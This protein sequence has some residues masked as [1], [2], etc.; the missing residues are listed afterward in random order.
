[1]IRQ[2]FLVAI[3]SKSLQV[4]HRGCTITSTGYV[5]RCKSYNCLLNLLST[6][7]TKQIDCETGIY[8][9][10]LSMALSTYLWHILNCFFS[11]RIYH[12]SK[13]KQICKLSNLLH[14]HL[15]YSF[16]LKRMYSLRSVQLLHPP[17]V[18]SSSY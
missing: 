5:R 12:F 14:R 2:L 1:M 3:A 8:S 15:F 4:N 13:R 9:Q 7:F 17:L 6:L 16:I 11:N 10:R 18:T